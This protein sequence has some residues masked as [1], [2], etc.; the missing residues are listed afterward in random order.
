MAEGEGVCVCVGPA[1]PINGS[2]CLNIV[3]AFTVTIGEAKSGDQPDR[4]TARRHLN[5]DRS[6]SSIA[7][8]R[9][10]SPRHDDNNDDDD[11]NDD[12]KD[13]IVS[14]C[15]VGRSHVHAAPLTLRNG[16]QEGVVWEEEELGRTATN[17]TVA[18]AFAAAVA[19]TSRRLATGEAY[20]NGVPYRGWARSLPSHSWS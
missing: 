9:P 18:I 19:C 4:Q 10:G 8:P 1:D 17:V 15:Q 11:D 12:E 3:G 13:G 6:T 20:Q 5:A 2:G 16:T 7:C 14:G